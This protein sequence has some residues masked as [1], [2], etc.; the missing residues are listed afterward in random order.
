VVCHVK[1][2]VTPAEWFSIMSDAGQRLA[3]I[4]AG[5]AFGQQAIKADKDDPDKD[6]PDNDDEKMA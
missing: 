5:I 3:W 1:P 2:G 4:D 6:D